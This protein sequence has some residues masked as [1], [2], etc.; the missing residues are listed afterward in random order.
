MERETGIEPATFSLEVVIHS[1]SPAALVASSTAARR[2]TRMP[3]AA[4]RFGGPTYNRTSR[5]K[6]ANKAAIR[7]N[8]KVKNDKT[9]PIFISGRIA[10]NVLKLNGI[11]PSSTENIRRNRGALLRAPFAEA[12]P[13]VRLRVPMDGPGWLPEKGH[14]MSRAQ[15]AFPLRPRLSIQTVIELLLPRL[16][17]GRALA[18]FERRTLA[19][20]ADVVKEGSPV[21]RTGEEIATSVETF[22]LAGRSRR[23][24]RIRLLLHLLEYLPLLSTGRRLT[25]LDPEARSRLIQKKFG[26]AKGLW[27]IAAKAR[28]LVLMGL[29]GD[30][31]AP[32]ATGFVPPEKRTRYT[33]YVFPDGPGVPRPGRAQE[34]SAP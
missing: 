8:G 13:N 28:Y 6:G 22:L 24:W 9:N 30:A 5:G 19:A 27:W 32:A 25:S 10:L 20:V 23:A 31:S 12:T 21:E 2:I 3:A 4:G 14:A 11:S 26:N 7:R 29:Y 17:E 15:K 34:K 33:G 18:P 1:T 16:P